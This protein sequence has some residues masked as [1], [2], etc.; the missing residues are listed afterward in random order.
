LSLPD[1]V[2]NLVAD[3]ELSAGHARALLALAPPHSPVELARDAVQQGH[4]V[5]ELERR[6]RG[7][8]QPVAEQVQPT[9]KPNREQS[10]A[11]SPDPGVRQIEDQLRRYLQTDV[12]VQPSGEGKGT[13]RI[14]FYS[15]DD[16]DRL[17]D[18]ILR[19]RRDIY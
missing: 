11:R 14:G 2:Q 3:G 19:E 16:L 17:L 12:L 9:S 15:A 13:V 5:R 10:P 18:L 8:M 1:E 4:S 7:L 6:V